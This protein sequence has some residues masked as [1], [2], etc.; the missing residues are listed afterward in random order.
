MREIV[1][2]LEIELAEFGGASGFVKGIDETKPV[3]E[4]EVGIEDMLTSLGIWG[5]RLVK[6][7]IKGTKAL[8]S[9]WT[10]SA[11]LSNFELLLSII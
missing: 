2:L 6:E 3:C 11:T 10:I 4:G 9:S 5:I 8:E 1:H 7:G